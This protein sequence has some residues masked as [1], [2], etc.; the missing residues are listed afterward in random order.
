MT[1]LTL[2][3]IVYIVSDSRQPPFLPAFFNSP[4]LL[5]AFFRF[6]AAYT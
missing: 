4:P 2:V 3:G 6:V 1:L 5:P